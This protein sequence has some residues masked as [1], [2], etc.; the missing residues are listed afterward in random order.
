MRP[1]RIAEQKEE[2]MSRIS[3]KDQR[4]GCQPRL[5]GYFLRY[6]PMKRA[7]IRSKIACERRSALRLRRFSKRNRRRFRERCRHAR[8]SGRPTGHRHGHRERK[9]IGPFGA[10][11]VSVP[12]A[13]V[14]DEAGKTT[15]WRSK[16]PWRGQRLTKKAGALIASACLAGT[17]TRRVKRALYGLFE[18]AARKEVVSRAWRK[19]G[20][21]WAQGEG[22]PGRLGRAQ[23]GR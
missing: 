2:S 18:G 3:G 10:E 17:S 15:E 16:A 23:P 6:C 22:R 21:G 1:V 11:T 9:L 7:M 4:Y 14:P 13:R 20:V 19:M 8:G 5:V 12:R